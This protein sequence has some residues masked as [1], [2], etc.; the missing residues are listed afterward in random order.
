VKGHEYITCR[1][2]VGFIADYLDGSLPS[3][4]RHEFERHLKVCP[5]CVAYLEGYKESVRLGK[6]AMKPTEDP[7]PVPESLVKAIRAARA[8]GV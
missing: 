8:R 7:A 6:L 2:L 1:E 3:A 4:M 5:S